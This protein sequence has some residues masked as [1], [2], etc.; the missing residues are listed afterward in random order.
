L[1]RIERLPG[2]QSAAGISFLPLAGPGIGTS[3]YRLDQPRPPDGQLPSTVVSPVT[4]GF[5][6]T[7]GIRQVAGR[8]FAPSD[9][10]D[11]PQVA[12]VSEGLVNRFL[13]GENPI[14]KRLWV[15]VGSAAG[16][17]VEI[18][19]VVGD[20]KFASLDADTRATIYIPHPQLAVGL[21]TF[22]VRTGLEPTS[23]ASSVGAAVRAI[24]PELPLADVRTMNDVVDATLARPRARVG[25]PRRRSRSSLCFSPASACTA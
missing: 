11:S 15:S 17:Q 13:T 4:P 24:D 14:G 22:V 21:M 12:V 2:V 7:M 5:F 16:M 18:V 19:G 25:A 9:T 20:V 8:D 1:S 6:R 3:F 23:L 10:A